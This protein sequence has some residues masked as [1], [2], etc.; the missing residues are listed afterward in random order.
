MSQNSP[1]ALPMKVDFPASTHLSTTAER[2]LWPWAIL[3]LT[4]ALRPVFSKLSTDVGAVALFG[5]LGKELLLHNF[6]QIVSLGKKG[7]R[8]ITT[9]LLKYLFSVA[10][11]FKFQDSELNLVLSG[12]TCVLSRYRIQW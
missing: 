11:P 2:A 5:H 3:T 10:K 12:S 1:P 9:V 8:G 6:L 7:F 4:L